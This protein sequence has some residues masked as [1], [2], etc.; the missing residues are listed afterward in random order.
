MSGSQGEAA[1]ARLPTSRSQTSEVKDKQLHFAFE[2]QYLSFYW[3]GSILKETQ[4]SFRELT[5]VTEEIRYRYKKEKAQE[6]TQ[7]ISP[8]PPALFSSSSTLGK[9]I[10][11]AG[12]ALVSLPL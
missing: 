4:G 10:V 8:T 12:F 11:T 3:Q 1:Q 5:N 9:V 2:I 7:K 6:H